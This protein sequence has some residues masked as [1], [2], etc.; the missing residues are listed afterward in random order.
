MRHAGFFALMLLAL[1]IAMP[2][3]L[4][5]AMNECQLHASQ[6]A[7]DNCFQAAKGAKIVWGLT[8]AGALIASITLHLRHSRWRYAALCALAIGPWLAMSA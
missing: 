7:V 8:V 5:W 3:A 1:L 4:A 6:P 2:T